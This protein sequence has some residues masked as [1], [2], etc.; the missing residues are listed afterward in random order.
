MAT[1]A[2]SLANHGQNGTKQ[3]DVVMV[4]VP[5]PA[6]GHLNQ[7]L[8][9]SRLVSS[10]NLQ[11]HYVGFNAFIRQAKLR[12]HGWDPV[13]DT[14]HPNILFKEIHLPS[15]Y[16]VRSPCSN[17]SKV[18]ASTL[19]LSLTLRKP[20]I[21]FLNELSTTTRKV[22]IVYDSLMAFVVQDIVSIP[23]VEAYCFHAVSA[24]TTSSIIWEGIENFLRLPTFLGKFARKFLKIPQEL[25]SLGSSFTHEFLDFI[26]MQDKHHNICSGNLFDTCKVVEGPYLQ[27]LAKLHRLLRRGNQWALGPFNPIKIQKDSKDHCHKCLRWLDKQ[28]PNSV[29]L[30]S[31]GTTSSLSSDQ[32]KELAMG[33]EKSDQKFIW[34]VRDALLEE[35]EKVKIPNGYEERIKGRGIIVKDWAPQFEILGHSSTGGFMSHCGWNSCMESITMGVPIASWPMSFDQPRNAVLVTNVLKIGIVVK[36]WE[37]RDDLVTSTIVENCVRK[38][39]DSPEGDKMRMR[40]MELGKKVRESMMDGGVSRMEMDSFIAHVTRD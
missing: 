17:M 20:L 15:S 10:Y 11:V 24:F 7:L 9:L 33:L 3:E 22:V 8:H 37:C 21:A 12:V 2:T 23:N 14:T 18:I 25:P 30:V 4:M 13:T 32:I 36:D 5:F 26:S 38:L 19:D 28:E 29:L 39:M 31:F 35:G 16:K 6:Q 40:A 1:N 27:I 34:V